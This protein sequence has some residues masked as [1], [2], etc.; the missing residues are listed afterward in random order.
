MNKKLSI[1]VVTFISVFNFIYFNGDTVFAANDAIMS[2]GAS[3][4]ENS[5]L[6]RVYAEKLKAYEQFVQAVNDNKDDI[7][8]QK[9]SDAYKAA[10]EKYNTLL[11]KNN[12]DSILYNNDANGGAGQPSAIE[13][14]A[15]APGLEGISGELKN[16]IDIVHTYNG[17]SSDTFKLKNTAAGNFQKK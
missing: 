7:T 2:A 14:A 4:A 15:A 10:L 16:I 5:A 11:S 17:H 3:A 6:N 12:T 1:L 8:I 9:L 13:T